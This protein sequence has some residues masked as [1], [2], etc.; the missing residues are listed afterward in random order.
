MNVIPCKIFRVLEKK[1]I[2]RSCILKCDLFN[3]LLWTVLGLHCYVDVSSCDVQASHCSAFS[4]CGSQASVVVLP[5]PWNTRSVVAVFGLCCSMACGIFPDQG[6]NPCLLHWQA[7]S[8]PLNY[9]GGPLRSFKPRT[10][11]CNRSMKILSSL[12]CVRHCVLHFTYISSFYARH[13]HLMTHS[14][15][16]LGKGRPES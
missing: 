3:Y 11:Y 14:Y 6:M 10:S 5:G 1:S 12:L 13:T 7:N 2:L 9:Q 16:R 8:L 4:C 15:C